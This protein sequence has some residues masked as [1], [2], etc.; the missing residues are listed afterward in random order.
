MKKFRNLVNNYKY[1]DFI[2]DKTELK[3]ELEYLLY[4]VSCKRIK[5]HRN[6]MVNLSQDFRLLSN[7]NMN[8]RNV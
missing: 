2:V 7:L 1:S 5:K 6:Q 8:T 3:L 4:F